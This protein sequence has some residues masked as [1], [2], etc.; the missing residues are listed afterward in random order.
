MREI[1]DCA[2]GVEL[3]LVFDDLVDLYEL[4]GPT[5]SII[6]P[7]LNP[8]PHPTKRELEDH[9]RTGE[10]RVLALYDDARLVNVQLVVNGSIAACWGPND[11][12]AMNAAQ[13]APDGFAAFYE[14]EG[15]VWRLDTDAP[16]WVARDYFERY[17]RQDEG[18]FVVDALDHPGLAGRPLTD[19]DDARWTLT[20]SRP[21]PGSPWEWLYEVE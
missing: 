11:P 8:A 9:I 5:D 2:I 12:T 20:I 17:A 16:G 4:A 1:T 7:L 3:D 10:R 19:F 6:C 21:S 14:A 13:L 18:P 15:S